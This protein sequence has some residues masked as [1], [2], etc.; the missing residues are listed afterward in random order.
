MKVLSFPKLLKILPYLRHK[1]VTGLE[2]SVLEDEEDVKPEILHHFSETSRSD[3]ESTAD[4]CQEL[5]LLEKLVTQQKEIITRLDY[6]NHNLVQMASL[7]YQHIVEDSADL[8]KTGRKEPLFSGNNSMPFPSMFIPF[9]MPTSAESSAY[10]TY[11]SAPRP[12][13]PYMHYS[14]SPSSPDH[15]LPLNAPYMPSS[16][17]AATYMPASQ[18][19]ASYIPTSQILSS[20][21]ILPSKSTS[22]FHPSF[23]PTSL[24]SSPRSTSH[25]STMTLAKKHNNKIP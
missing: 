25:P 3:T 21:C 19:A 1:S 12:T 9:P 13:A 24:G 16:Q 22:N 7:H 2:S 4:K 20:L 17:P 8:L 23:S 11:I 6:L 15:S 14:Q 5:Q 18:P 10:T